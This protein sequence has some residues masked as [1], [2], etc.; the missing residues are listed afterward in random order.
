MYSAL[1]AALTVSGKALGKGYAKKHS[2][3]IVHRVGKI[4]SIFHK[5]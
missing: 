3:R 2:T 5:D 1:I 4:L